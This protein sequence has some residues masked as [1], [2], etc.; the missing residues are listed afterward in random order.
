MNID[1]KLIQDLMIDENLLEGIEIDE[2]YPITPIKS[3]SSISVPSPSFIDFNHVINK[4][5]Q[6]DQLLDL[7]DDAKLLMSQI[8][9]QLELENKTGVSL[10]DDELLKQ[11][12][13]K[14]ASLKVSTNNNIQSRPLGKVPTPSTLTEFVDE[15][16]FWCCICNED[17]QV[18]CKECDDD[19]YCVRCFREGHSNDLELR[20][21]KAEKIN[22]VNI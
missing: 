20:K 2:M 4:V 10:D 12:L 6:S 3:K 15:T 18:T 13:D 19:V 14:L 17:G 11:R 21:H 7:D 22:K 16:D 8:K 5:T 9:L 1:D